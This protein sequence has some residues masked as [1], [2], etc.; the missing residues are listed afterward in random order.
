MKSLKIQFLAFSLVLI[1]SV[2]FTTIWNK[3]EELRKVLGRYA[4]VS[5]PCFKEFMKNLKSIN[6]KVFV[7]TNGQ[8]SFNELGLVAVSDNK[9]SV[10]IL[11]KFMQVVPKIVKNDECSEKINM[12]FDKLEMVVFVEKQY[13]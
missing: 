1:T 13:S 11:D 4:S 7:F 8:N 2:G 12:S 6:A 3:E 9:D 5:D 10:L